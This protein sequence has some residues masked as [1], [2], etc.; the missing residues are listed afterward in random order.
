[1]CFSVKIYNYNG[2]QVSHISSHKNIVQSLSYLEEI[3]Q[4]ILS[5]VDEQTRTKYETLLK[6]YSKEMKIEKKAMKLGLKI[7]SKLLPD[8]ISDKMLVFYLNKIRSGR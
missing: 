1:V 5:K 4:E 3:K 2:Y 6:K 8:D 7:I